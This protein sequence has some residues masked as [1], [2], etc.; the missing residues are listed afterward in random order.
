VRGAADIDGTITAGSGIESSDFVAGSSGWR[1]DGD[2]SAE[3]DA[4]LIRGEISA[5]TGEV[6]GW[7]IVST[8]IQ[9][10]DTTVRIDSSE[11]RF[12]VQDAFGTPKTALGYL[13]NLP[14]FTIDEFGLFVGYGNTV[15]FSSGGSFEEGSYM[16]HSDQVTTTLA[17]RES[18]YIRV[19]NRRDFPLRLSVFS[20]NDRRRSATIKETAEL[21]LDK[22]FFISGFQNRGHA[23]SCLK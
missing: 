1:I 12:E 7:D 16:I 8:R 14:G 10:D 11:R 18:A 9:S 15:S 6:G 22:R 13:G 23:R 5:D 2:G 19:V 21:V 17:Q 20:T 3:F 4:A